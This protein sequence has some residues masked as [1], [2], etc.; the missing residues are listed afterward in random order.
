MRKL[1]K[2]KNSSG[3]YVLCTYR[4]HQRPIVLYRRKRAKIF[5]GRGIY[6]EAES[7]NEMDLLV[8]LI[9]AGQE[10]IGPRRRSRGLLAGFRGGGRAALLAALAEA[11]GTAAAARRLLPFQTA[12][13]L[14]LRGPP[15][16]NFP[17]IAFYAFVLT[18][19]HSLLFLEYTLKSRGWLFTLLRGKSEPALWRVIDDWWQRRIGFFSL[20]ERT[21]QGTS[22]FFNR[23]CMKCHPLDFTRVSF[24]S[25]SCRF[26]FVWVPIEVHVQHYVVTP[27][28]VRLLVYNLNIDQYN[29]HLLQCTIAAVQLIETIVHFSIQNMYNGLSLYT[30]LPKES[31]LLLH[32]STRNN[33]SAKPKHFLRSALQKRTKMCPPKNVG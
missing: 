31:Q 22:S 19:V 25:R 6:K 24:F 2:S 21:L 15:L 13:Q 3:I 1:R 27:R 20:P 10:L 16:F 30:L 17:C 26:I 28:T 23:R 5:R 18:Y 9:E 12:Q 14:L 7:S 11:T 33:K 32:F 8:V 29:I 4:H